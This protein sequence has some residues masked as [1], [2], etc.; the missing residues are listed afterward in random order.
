MTQSNG[1][2]GPSRTRAEGLRQWLRRGGWVVPT[3][4]LGVA[5]VLATTVHL[6]PDYEALSRPPAATDELPPAVAARYDGMF[7]LGSLRLLG[8]SDATA[9]Y[10]ASPAD[11]A[12]GLC[13]IAA[14]LTD[15]GL[16]Q[17]GCSSPGISA[18]FQFADVTLSDHRPGDAWVEIAEDVWRDTAYEES[19]SARS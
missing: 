16:S 17:A 2:L 10:L 18:G 5:A 15:P 6:P 11:A 4:G 13:F 7:A 14:N 9:Y 1:E 12:S 3:A 8:E 19:S